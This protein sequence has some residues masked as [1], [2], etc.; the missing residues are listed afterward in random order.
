MSQCI[1]PSTLNFLC[2]RSVSGELWVDLVLCVGANGKISLHK[3]LDLPTIN[4]EVITS[5][6]LIG[7]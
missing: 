3:G 7:L 2:L 4:L 5:N 6:Y 1:V